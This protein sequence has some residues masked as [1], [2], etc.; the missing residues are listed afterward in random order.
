MTASSLP[1]SLDMYPYAFARNNLW[2]GKVTAQKGWSAFNRVG[3]A[4][5]TFEDHEVL[6]TFYREAEQ[7][8]R[9]QNVDSP[10]FL[11]LALTAPHTPT[12]PGQ[13]LAREEFAGRLRRLRDGSRSCRTTR[14]RNAALTGRG[15][16][17]AH[18][19]FIGS[20]TCLVCWQHPEGDAPARCAS[21]RN[22]GITPMGRIGGTSFPSTKE[23][24]ACR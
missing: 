9:R 4:E 20:R 24:C 17:H 23:A 10:F 18:F 19:A 1:G 16:E 7:F 13:G 15:G 12:S 22:K 3:P 14:S 11:Y 5:E 21:W 6:E 8:I 2:Q